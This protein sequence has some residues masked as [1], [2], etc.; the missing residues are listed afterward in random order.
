MARPKKEETF[1]DRLQLRLPS[2]LK[3]QAKIIALQKG[4]KGISEYIV[5][6]LKKDGLK[7]E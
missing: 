6:L 4:Y 3:T 7:E 2:E 5:D 1:D